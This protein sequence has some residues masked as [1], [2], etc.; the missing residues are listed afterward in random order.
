MK[1]HKPKGSPKQGAGKKI[2][3]SKPVKMGKKN[4]GY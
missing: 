1:G 2:T 3:P 4:K